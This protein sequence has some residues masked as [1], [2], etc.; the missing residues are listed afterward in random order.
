MRI[1][2]LLALALSAPAAFAGTAPF[3]ETFD[4]G[5]AN[6]YDGPQNPAAWDSDGF[7][8]STADVNSAGGFGLLL[9]RA[10][11][12]YNS[13]NGAFTGDYVGNIDT[14]SFDVRHD[15]GQDLSFAVRFATAA[16]SPAFVLF[17]PVSVASGDW[18]T[19]SFAIDPN[20]P[21]YAPAGG[22]FDAVAG[23]VGN[24][25]VIV[26]RPDGLSTPLVTTFDLDNVAITPA[27]G[28]LGLLGLGGA[29]VARRRRG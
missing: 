26:N 21:F 7:I 20:S 8:T 1:A 9:F 24:I 4:A 10:Q 18:T 6:W 11:S 28:A 22:T 17:S 25:Q 19:L 12:N 2:S 14:I 16:N 13:S 5:N 29:F 15:A 3:T 27:P 23:Q